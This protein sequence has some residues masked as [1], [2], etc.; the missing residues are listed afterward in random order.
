[1][2]SEERMGKQMAQM[3][4]SEFLEESSLKM[5]KSRGGCY[6]NVAAGGEGYFR[7]FIL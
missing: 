4:M 1:M 6:R 5:N 7:L 3:T 2:D